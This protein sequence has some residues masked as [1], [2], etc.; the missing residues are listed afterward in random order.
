MHIISVIKDKVLSLETERNKYVFKQD[1][2]E[3]SDGAHLTSFGIVP[4]RRRS[5][6]KRAIIKC[7][8]T[9]CRSIEKRHSV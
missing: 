6:R 4:D 5:K 8:P 7:C 9:V 3:N 2:N 1:L